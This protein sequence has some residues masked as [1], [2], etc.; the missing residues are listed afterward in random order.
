MGQKFW[1]LSYEAS[2]E[3]L[4]VLVVI[5]VWRATKESLEKIYA[6]RKQGMFFLDLC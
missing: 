5:L 4:S 2:Y 6:Q 3:S 1:L